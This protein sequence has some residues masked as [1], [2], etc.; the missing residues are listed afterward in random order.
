MTKT[1]LNYSTGLVVLLIAL[2]ANLTYIQVIK[3]D[4]LRAAPG[5]SRTVLDEYSTERGPILV[6]SAPAAKSEPSGGDLK[7]QRVYPEGPKYVPATGFYSLVYGRTALERA[8]NAVLSGTDER[9]FVD[10]LQQLFGGRDPQGGGVR[11]T[12]NAA[13]QQAAWSGLQGKVG[14]VAAIEPSTGFILALVQ[15]PSFDPNILASQDSG[16]A[17]DYYNQLTSDSAEPMLNRPLVKS[18]P[19]GS[20]FKLVTAAAALESGRF[21]AD[22]I[23]PGP[24]TY[25]L[26]G[27]STAVGNWTGRAC[28]PNDQVT[29]EE[30]LAISC[31]TAFLW[32]GNEL[33]DDALRRQSEKFGFNTSFDVPMTAAAGRYPQDASADQTA[34]SAIGQWDVRATALNMAQVTAAIANSGTTMAP[35]LVEAIESP[36]LTTLRTTSPVTFERR[37]MSQV[38][39]ASLMSMMVG[40]VNNGTGSNARIPGVEVGGKTGTAQTGE[41]RRNIAWFVAAAPADDPEVAVAVMIEDA[42]TNEVSGNQLAAPIARDVIAAVLGS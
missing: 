6:D 32:L 38:N 30:A 26:P 16:R 21:S 42:G 39:A 24:A 29:L 4:E 8:E 10:R 14:A 40:V 9:L 18:V 3:N 34:Q 23:L 41:G 28:G 33:G 31:N 35:Y 15:S 17:Q 1:I 12:L 36:D 11:T 37:A 5:N 7:Y 2:L 22:S 13:A 27:T 20:T 19:P 25:T